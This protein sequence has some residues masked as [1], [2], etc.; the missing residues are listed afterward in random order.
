MGPPR[1]RSARADGIARQDYRSRT[2]RCTPVRAVRTE[3]V[4][5][6][7]AFNSAKSCANT[8]TKDGRRR[9]RAELGGAVHRPG[10]H[11]RP[12]QEGAGP[13]ARIGLPEP[14]A[15]G[16]RV[17][18]TVARPIVRAERNDLRSDLVAK[19]NS[20]V[21]ALTV[22]NLRERL[23]KRGVE[24]CLP[25]REQA[26]EHAVGRRSGR[27]DLI[28]VAV[29]SDSDCVW[30][31]PGMNGGHCIRHGDMHHRHGA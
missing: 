27:G 21:L 11:R 30:L 10:C 13:G 3:L 25:C 28:G 19:R 4:V 15:D 5:P 18:Q 26:H 9:F 24:L 31:V 8:V 2:W 29:T 12:G 1:Q 20:S 23:S 16:W 22:P 17:R 7:I 6:P 14:E